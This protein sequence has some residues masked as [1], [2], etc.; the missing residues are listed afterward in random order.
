MRGRF[1]IAAEPRSPERGSEVGRLTQPSTVIAAIEDDF[2]AAIN[3]ASCDHR[4]MPEQA[5]P[6]FAERLYGEVALWCTTPEIGS[7]RIVDM[8][9]DALVAGL[10][11]EG[12]RAVAGTSVGHEDWTFDASV[13]TMLAELGREF[14]GRGTAIAQLGAVQAMCRRCLDGSVSPR[15]L[16]RWAHVVVGHSGAPE[17]QVLVELD[18]A[19]DTVG[20]SEETSDDLDKSVTEEA[21]RLAS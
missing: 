20:Y 13:Q 5:D 9:C 8:A 21:R 17:A 3:R 18:D 19:Y 2:R 4:E 10:D 14:P 15:E 11:G 16:A 1:V 12:V 7:A 6:E